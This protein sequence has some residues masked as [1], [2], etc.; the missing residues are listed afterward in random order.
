MTKSAALVAAVGLWLPLCVV[1]NA[2]RIAAQT[3]PTSPTS[4]CSAAVDLGSFCANVNASEWT[5]DPE[6][7][8]LAQGRAAGTNDGGDSALEPAFPASHVWGLLHDALS[9]APPTPP[10]QRNARKATIAWRAYD[11]AKRQFQ[12][13][14]EAAMEAVMHYVRRGKLVLPSQLMV[15][16]EVAA[17]NVQFKPSSRTKRSP[18]TQVRSFQSVASFEPGNAL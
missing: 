10:R 3:P 17:S 18:K 16:V 5:L 8:A 9:L 7:I 6:L 11:M 14:V 13:K 4:V 1:C 12:R 15:E 2:T